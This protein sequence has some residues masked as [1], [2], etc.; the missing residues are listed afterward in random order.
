MDNN[1][2]DTNAIAGHMATTKQTPITIPANSI[3]REDDLIASRTVD[4]NSI[5][6]AIHQ[7]DNE[8]TYNPDEEQDQIFYL[9]E[10]NLGNFSNIEG[11]SLDQIDQDNN[12]VIKIGIANVLQ[13]MESNEKDE[14]RIKGT[15]LSQPLSPGV[16]FSSL[17]NEIPTLI[18]ASG[19]DTVD[20]GY[21]ANDQ[22]ISLPVNKLDFEMGSTFI[23]VV[24]EP[25]NAKSTHTTLMILKRIAKSGLNVIHMDPKDDFALQNLAIKTDQGAKQY[26]TNNGFE[27]KE[28][29]LSLD[30]RLD[31]NLVNFEEI[32]I[33]LKV[34]NSRNTFN[35]NFNTKMNE[36]FSNLMFKKLNK[37]LTIDDA[38][39]KSY[40]KEIL[41]EM[42]K[43]DLASQIYSPT[44]KTFE[45]YKSNLRS[46]ASSEEKLNHILN[47]QK[48]VLSYFDKSKTYTPEKIIE[49]SFDNH[50]KTYFLIR[51]LSDKSKNKYAKYVVDYF[52]SKII[53]EANNTLESLPNDEKVN[54]ILITDELS[55]LTPSRKPSKFQEETIDAMISILDV[56]GRSRSFGVLFCTQSVEQI[57]D[58]VV[59]RLLSH[60]VHVGYGVRGKIIRDIKDKLNS[61]SNVDKLLAIPAPHAPRGNLKEYHFFV[62]GKY[63][64]FSESLG[65]LY[66]VVVGNEN[67][68]IRNDE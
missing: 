29:D 35:S 12:N 46:V 20:I 2:L 9:S 50:K 41:E 15:K 34:L 53:Q 1:L 52:T 6:I 26:L 49:E 62:I 3:A 65:L 44:G 17:D 48:I 13:V 56:T 63:S 59:S 22:K 31:L 27:F 66:K 23:F 60:E 33:N 5:T 38:T 30:V 10:R 18:E 14:V 47:L 24:A 51:T 32:T 39:L 7:I 16:E 40:A 57:E 58:R 19:Y 42:A 67:E 21:F 45:T 64:L 61:D 43:N 36:Q 11:R 68:S 4:G 8:T 54:T 37:N 25:G 28:I 55:K